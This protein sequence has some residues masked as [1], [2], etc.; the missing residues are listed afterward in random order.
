M[1]LV[2]EAGRSPT[3]LS[4]TECPK[5]PFVF[6]PRL[7]AALTPSVAECGKDDREDED[8]L[9]RLPRGLDAHS[10]RRLGLRTAKL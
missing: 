3:P 9:A 8:Q 6:W 10:T 1:E 2:G 7:S 4:E 5:A